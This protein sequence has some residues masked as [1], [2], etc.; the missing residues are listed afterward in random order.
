MAA[1]SSRGREEAA[2]MSFEAT[3]GLIELGFFY[4]VVLGFGI[5][6]LVKIRREIARDAEAKATRAKKSDDQSD[7]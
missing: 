5:W 6:Q 2:V 7:K 1:D 3:A 4:T